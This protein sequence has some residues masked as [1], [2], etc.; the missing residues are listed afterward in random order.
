MFER[1]E[2]A[3]ALFDALRKVFQHSE[4]VR[5]SGSYEVP[6][7]QLVADRERVVMMANEAWKV[8]GYRFT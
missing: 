5:F 3:Q 6:A 2:G 8:S 1:F 4:S 7:D